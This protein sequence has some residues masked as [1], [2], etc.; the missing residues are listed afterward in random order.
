MLAFHSQTTCPD[1]TLE[2]ENT[3]LSEADILKCCGN[4]SKLSQLD[5]RSVSEYS[6]NNPTI[7]TNQCI[8]ADVYSLP[9]CIDEM[10]STMLQNNNSVHSSS[11]QKRGPS[12]VGISRVNAGYA[13]YNRYCSEYKRDNSLL[14]YEKY[15]YEMPEED[16]NE[17][18]KRFLHKKVESLYGE[19][20]ADQWE[21]KLPPRPTQSDRSPSCPPGEP[22]KLESVNGMFKSLPKLKPL[23]PAGNVNAFG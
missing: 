20:F 4:N 22:G 19:T 13:N 11:T 15:S 10:N 23:D 12:Y 2:S 1:S 21:R 3:T 8:K 17:S 9:T 5:Y 7:N 14:K 6:F 18:K 16:S